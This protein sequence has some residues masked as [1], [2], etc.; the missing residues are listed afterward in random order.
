MVV[1][2][3]FLGV[4]LAGSV[5]FAVLYGWFSERYGVEDLTVAAAAVCIFTWP[6]ALPVFA[7]MAA[8]AGL[9][10]LGGKLARR[11]A[12]KRRRLGWED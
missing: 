5:V 12:R 8:I 3:W 1:E 10:S 7:A 9:A 2:W 6:I 4:Y 11:G